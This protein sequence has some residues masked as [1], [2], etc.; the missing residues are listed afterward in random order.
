[1][2]LPAAV[3][4]G[5]TGKDQLRR[6]KLQPFIEGL[7]A[8]LGGEQAHV[9]QAGEFLGTLPGW[10]DALTELSACA[11]S[12]SAKSSRFSPSCAWRAPS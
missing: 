6:E 12:P 3:A 1:M 7:L 2:Q 10:R 11:T 9:Q 5:D 4:G 8:H